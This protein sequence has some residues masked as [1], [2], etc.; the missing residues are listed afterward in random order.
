MADKEMIVVDLGKGKADPA[1]SSQMD[2]L[3]EVLLAERAEKAL[4]TADQKMRRKLAQEQD[5]AMIKEQE[6]MK[7]ARQAACTHV[8]E[9]G[10]TAMAGQ[11]HNDGLVHLFCQRCFW[12]QKPFAPTHE[13]LTN[14]LQIA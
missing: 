12:E 5:I 4:E 1:P 7:A 9:N 6:A 13:H 8:K 10:K 11:I 14:G 2:R 3:L